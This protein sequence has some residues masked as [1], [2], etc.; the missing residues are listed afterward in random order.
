MQQPKRPLDGLWALDMAPVSGIVNICVY[1]KAPPSPP[2]KKKDSGR[3]RC[4]SQRETG[5]RMNSWV[6]KEFNLSY[7]DKDIVNTMVSGLW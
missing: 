2:P 1:A 3:P 4:G 5:R 6:A 7:H